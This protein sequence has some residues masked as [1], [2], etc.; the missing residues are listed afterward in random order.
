MLDLDESRLQSIS[1]ECQLLNPEAKIKPMTFV[2][3]VGDTEAVKTFV[4]NTVATFGKINILVNN[5]GKTKY[6]SLLKST[7]EDFD[8][9]FNINIRAI[10]HLTSLVAP[11]LIKTEGSVVNIAS[12]AGHRVLEGRLVYGMSKGCVHT[13]TR[14]AAQ[15][16]AVHKVRMNSI[17][18]GI[19]NTK[20]TQAYGFTEA[21]HKKFLE[22]CGKSH[23]LGRV[24]EAEE[25]A[26]VA[27]FLA[28]DDSSFT[29]GADF[30][31]DG[32]F[33]VMPTLSP[34]KY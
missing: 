28:S 24:G 20:L 29:T 4:Q 6:T 31:I 10:F 12:I 25:I 33:S 27:L 1:A 8:E 14:Y 5:A 34:T 21:E 7:V 13:F 22:S 23:A 11:Y 30:L 19:I 2:G 3:N 16:L 26:N 9:V 15:E 17:S 18:P 32:G